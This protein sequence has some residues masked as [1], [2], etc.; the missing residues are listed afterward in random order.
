MGSPIDARRSPTIPN[1][2]AEEKSFDWFQENMIHTVPGPYPGVFRR[3]YPGFVQL[4]SFMNMNWGRHV[5]AQWQFF[6][7]LV[8]GDGNDRIFGGNGV[9][10]CRVP[11]EFTVSCRG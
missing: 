6:N 5:D 8:G 4:A 7:H 10:R 3:G 9:D 1:E 11:V 2:L